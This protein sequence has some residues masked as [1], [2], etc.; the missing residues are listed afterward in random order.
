MT[1]Y[2]LNSI[3]TS[4]QMNAL[5]ARV[6]AAQAALPTNVHSY[7]AIGD[8][9]SRP[10]SSLYPT[11]AAA[12]LVYPHATALTQQLDWAGIQAA[13]NAVAAR[14]DRGGKVFVPNAGAAYI[15][16]ETLTI[17]PRSTSFVSDGAALDF[18]TLAFG[19]NG[20]LLRAT[21]AG[22][23]GHSKN[24]MQGFELIGPGADAA[25]VATTACFCFDTLIAGLSSRYY[26]ADLAVHGWPRA[27]EF[28]NRAYLDRFENCD[29]Y[30]CTQCVHF[31]TGA[32]AGENLSFVQCA[33]YNSG[34]AIWNEIGGGMHFLACS[35]DYNG[36]ALKGMWG[37]NRFVACHFEHGAVLV[38]QIEVNGGCCSFDGCWYLVN[39]APLAVATFKTAAGATIQW[40]TGRASGLGP[41]LHQGSGV[42]HY[43]SW[44]TIAPGAGVIDTI[45]GG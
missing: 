24:R 12:K 7:G 37:E 5:D 39:A 43:G 44:T 17:N 29:F 8:G 3:L 31:G 18:T 14:G 19:K 33:F 26:L 28:L 34:V 42:F 38:P 23:Y 1:T 40:G 6:S 45:L 2:A 10:L 13:L 22:I 30:E 32:D 21:G 16:N 36:V 11:L 35:F 4:A 41:V 15:L 9:V 20:F 27:V 25:H